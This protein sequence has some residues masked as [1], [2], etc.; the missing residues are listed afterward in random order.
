MNCVK[1]RPGEQKLEP[2][3]EKLLRVPGPVGIPYQ[4]DPEFQPY[5]VAA[6]LSGPGSELSPQEREIV[7]RLLL[8][9][10][11]QPSLP[12][13]TLLRYLPRGLTLSP[14]QD[15]LLDSLGP[16]ARSGEQKEAMWALDYRQRPPSIQEFIDADPVCVQLSFLSQCPGAPEHCRSVTR[17]AL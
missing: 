5:A 13:Q 12:R 9:W 8:R 3:G 15:Q 11:L 16:A 2:N 10:Q 7:R 1:Q 14:G 17:S 6:P 4:F